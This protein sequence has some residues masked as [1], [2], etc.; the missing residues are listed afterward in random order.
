LRLKHRSSDIFL[1]KGLPMKRRSQHLLLAERLEC[2]RLLAA[3]FTSFA[4]GQVASLAWQGRQV[5]AYADRWIVGYGEAG[6]DV[7]ANTLQ[8]VLDRSGRVGW[9][10]VS[11]GA[12]LYA[13]TAPGAAIDTVVG[14]GRSTP[15]IA[16]VEPDFAINR[17]LFPN[18]PSLS[19]LWGLHNTGQSGGL[20][21]A[22][23]DAPE[24][25]DK[26]TGSRSVVIGVIDSGIDVN[27]PDLAA[28]IWRNPGEIAGNRIDDDAN[29]YVDDITGWDFASSDNNPDDGNG[30]GTHVAGTIGAAGNDGRGVAGVNWQ[31]SLLPL[32]FLGTDGSGSTTGAIA[33]I[34]YATALRNRGV[35]VVATNNSW[36]GGGF[37]SGLQ[38]A[39]QNHANA[40]ILFVAAAGNESANNDTTA[41]YPANYPISNIISVA[42]LDRSDAL[43]SFSNY[44]PTK[45]HIGAPG[46]SIYSTTPSNQY[47]SYSGTS[48]ASPHV[49][50]VVGLLAAANPAATSAEIRSAILQSAVPVASLAGKT[51]TGGRLNA[52]AAL[53]RI[54][55]VAGPRVLSVTPSGFVEPPVTSVQVVFS[56]GITSAAVVGANF[57]LRG[58]GADGSFGTGDDI[59][60]PISDSQVAQSPAGTVTITP[61]S[62][63]AESAYRLRLVG[64]GANPLRNAAGQALAGGTDVVREFTVRV[65]PP[66]PPAPLEP[67]DTLATATSGLAAGASQAAF[68]GVIGDGQFTTRDVD[69]F[70]VQLNAGQT[71]VA[72]IRAAADGSTLDSYLRLFNA[73][74]TQLAF[75]D[76]FGGAFDSQ[77]TFTASATGT[78][79]VG[80]T[81]YGNSTYSPTT[82]GSGVAGSTGSY[83][84][85][86]QRTT[87]PLEPNDSMAQATTV[88][89]TSGAVSF[90]A[91]VGDGAAAAADVDLFRVQLAA[92]QKLTVDIDA[93]TLSPASGLD[94]YVRIFNAA[95]QQVAFNDDVGTALDSFLEYTATAAGTF[96][97]GVS[98]FGNSAYNP[99]TA[100]SGTSGSTGNYRLNLTFAT[101]APPPPP[102]TAATVVARHLFYNN[103]RHDGFDS[104]AGASDDAAIATDKSALL[105][106]ATA[107]FANY[108]SYSRGLNGVMID[109]ANL[110]GAPTLSDFTF[111]VGNTSTTGSWATAVAPRFLTVRAG[112]GVGGSSRVTLVWA[113][114]AI[115]QT[116]LE[117]TV[118][119]T[120]ATGLA[121]PHVFYFGNAIGEAGDTPANAIVS[122]SD[123]N[124]IAANA[125]AT[126]TIT[127]RYDVNRDGRVDSTDRSIA[128]LNRTTDRTALALISIAAP[129]AT[130]V[131]PPSAGIR[132]MGFRDPEQPASRALAFQQLGAWLLTAGSPVATA[133]PARLGVAPKRLA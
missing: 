87:P 119:A 11:L 80:V 99:A 26:T 74:G 47:A 17:S 65:V 31:V 64:T 18:D 60:V 54:A 124:L 120:A 82:G 70:S 41:S 132:I 75:N 37:S 42:A 79:Y 108:T 36:G 25:W 101:V 10:S 19:Q 24:A 23:I 63:L 2:R 121:A 112:A 94:S 38:T 103:S 89:A 34:N 46:V 100:G 67:N 122:M 40:G 68:S 116:W 51:T 33:A 69:M 49:A 5:D 114:S 28:N 115:R 72:A 107:T 58:A 29:G 129:A 96:Y 127:N 76:D 130:V 59:L 3:D 105:P 35:N 44:G 95:G 56:E 53:E 133:N 131:A 110:A 32:K 117:V 16:F 20:A 22:D 15:G 6:G 1:T 78:Y 30:H 13:V 7:A 55:P 90:T 62:G 77:I 86:I 106:G 123:V 9:T 84:I 126:A 4:S 104:R 109:V 48:M 97:V 81:G 92:G 73:S 21:D 102:P 91:V 85:T 66:P 71:V 125:A 50:G 111:R 118:R 83:Q 45:V 113:D 57:D 43:A 52:A 98:G 39:I 27:H 93:T 12:S 128:S 88:S 61:G 14:W 8:G